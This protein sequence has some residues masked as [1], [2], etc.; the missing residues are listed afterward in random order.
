MADPSYRAMP[1][2]VALALERLPIGV[3]ATA[4]AGQIAY[5]NPHFCRLVGHA[6]AALSG[7]DLAQLRHHPAPQV[8]LAMRSA[9]L[10]G[11]TWQ[12]ETALQT[13]RGVRHV[14]ESAYPVLD[15]GGRVTGSIHFFHEL[16]ALSA[17]ESLSRLAFYDS[18][19][20][21]PNRSLLEE[22]L[23]A[24]LAATRRSGKAFAVIYSD[25]EHFD[26][27]NVVLDR[28][29]G[30]DLL[31]LIARRMQHTLRA[32]DTIARIGGDEFAVLLPHAGGTDA[33]LRIGEKLR[34]ACSGWYEAAGRDYSVTLSVGVSVFSGDHKPDDLLAR[35]EGAMYRDK[36]ARRDGYYME[37]RFIGARYPLR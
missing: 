32:S 35:A 27:V 29:A 16:S 5:T 14:L 21:L 3:V 22:R 15:D 18:V 23:A 31:R 28:V 33:S 36:A 20:G 24:E 9:H 34:R 6:P 1:S 37:A 4:A 11:E 7:V 26:C 25:I 8:R 13:Q 10:A 12:G 17:S 2:D 19:T 30:D